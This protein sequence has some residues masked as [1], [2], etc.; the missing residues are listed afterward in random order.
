MPPYHRSAIAAI[1]AGVLVASAAPLLAA[2]PAADE[3]QTI[4]VPGAWEE[5]LP[6]RLFQN[7]S[8]L[9]PSPSPARGEGSNET[10]SQPAGRYDGF[11]WYRCFVDIPKAWQGESLRL[12]LGRI[13][14][15]DEAFFNGTQVGATGQMPPAYRGLSGKNRVYNIPANL[16]RPG[17]PNLIA[18]RVYD[19]GGTGG[20]V[21]GRIGLT[22]SRGECDLAGT[23]QFRLGDEPAWARWP[24]EPGSR[25]SK[26][27]LAGGGRF[28]ALALAEVVGS[29]Q[30]P[31]GENVLWYRQPA[32][33]WVEALPVGNGRLGGMVFGGVGRERI[34]LNDDALWAGGP[35]ER[36]NPEAL[37][38]LPEVRKLL[39]ADK[40]AEATALAGRT[41]MGIPP[42]IE[43]YQT[44][45]DLLVDVPGVERVTDYRRWLDLSAGTAITEYQFDGARFTQTVFSS[46][47]DQVLVV[48]FECDQP[49]RI[50]FAATVKRSQDARTTPL[51]QDGL[52]M[53]GVCNDGKGMR[54]EAH[55]KAA[56]KGGTVR[57]DG[58]RLMIEKADRITLLLAS[59][60]TLKHH[61]P[62]A[63]CQKQLAAAVAKGFATLRDAHTRDHAALFNRV[64]IDLG[65][66]PTPDLPTDER[67]AAVAQGADDPQLAALYFQF[68]RYLLMGSSRPGCLPANLQGIWNEHM[69][70]PWNADF[71]T[72]INLQMNYWP[73]EVCNL[74]EC[75]LPLM[76]LMDSLVAPGSKTA[77]IHYGCRGWVV[78][79]LTDVWGFTTPADGV[80]GVWP[81][82]GAWLAQHP[83]EHYRFSGDKRF[84]AERAYPLMKGAAR[85]MLDFLV[86]APP[87]T[88][89]AGRL[90]TCPSHSPEN[91]FRKPDGK[92]SMF[93]YAATM[94]LEIIHD[95]FTNCI[96]AIDTLGPG[97]RFDSEFRAELVS[98]LKRLAPLQVSKR[99]GALQE[100]VSDYEEP[101]PRHRHIS[102][103]F[104]LHPGRMITPRGTPD[105]CA[106]IQK[107]LERRGDAGTGWSRAW[108]VNAWA[109]LEDGDHAH[110]IFKGLLAGSTLPNL[111]DNHPPFQI[112]G[113]FGGAAGIAEML[114]QS[115]AGEIALLPALPTAWPTGRVE[116]LRARGGVEVSLAWKNC[117]A[118][119][120]QLKATANGRHNLRP[121]KG[122]TVNAVIC[123]GRPIGIHPGPNG[124]ASV[125]LQAEHE[126]SVRFE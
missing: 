57:A 88:P 22:C 100:W 60:T 33:R 99:T 16:V 47:P 51:G 97:G 98:A 78:H 126:Y 35:K 114:L 92:T 4:R 63:V 101:E 2:D 40:N 26:Q 106:A 76:D 17:Q 44:L 112:D 19:A 55:L 71:H 95:L 77:K 29:T 109:R 123:E 27:L 43:S 58:G 89:V 93:T 81:V 125:D 39:F 90:V 62:R 70:A 79:H 117:R 74:A 36:N 103:M 72:N 80:W 12:E 115:H 24:A 118:I 45:G 23:W 49:Q 68:G 61:D 15:A 1:M 85:F 122:Q 94:D 3:W 59:A 52:V 42:R 11:A 119:Q 7:I 64:K 102:H 6:H 20:I 108:K 110:L 73:V 41:M 34:Q 21:G 87:G 50:S 75:H 121:P 10:A 8:P 54:F 30:R 37:Q 69:A 53:A 84:L 86:E 120:A 31:S 91:S 18:V 9:T 96:E 83:Y 104:G 82:G 46:V 14:D 113:N 116:G 13:D 124:T 56:A 5:M 107:T 65:R 28:A 67:L 111:F 105:L 38:A 48:H 66:S 25:E 32:A